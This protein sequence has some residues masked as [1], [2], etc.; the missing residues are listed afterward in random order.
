M[1]LFVIPMP[2]RQSPRQGELWRVAKSGEESL[3]V[4]K[5]EEKRDS[6]SS[7]AADS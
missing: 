2:P 3:C 6:S 7:A 4:E 5:S 1:P